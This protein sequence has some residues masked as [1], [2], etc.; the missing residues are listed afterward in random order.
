[1]AD[2]V[3]HNTRS[4]GTAALIIAPGAEVGGAAAFP[5][6]GRDDNPGLTQ[7]SMQTLSYRGKQCAERGP[8][9]FGSQG[10]QV[11]PEH[12]NMEANGTRA[13]PVMQGTEASSVQAI[14]RGRFGR[15]L[16]QN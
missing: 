12:T 11:A 16:R 2:S 4:K 10:P 3:S 8:S 6:S 9:R 7:T 13:S 14:P 1:M 15:I 5:S